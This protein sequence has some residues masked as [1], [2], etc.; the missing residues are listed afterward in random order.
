VEH[1]QT[2]L[3]WVSSWSYPQTSDEAGKIAGDKHSSLHG[4][5]V[6]DEKESFIR[7]RLGQ[8]KIIDGKYLPFI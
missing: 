3:F 7:L 6:S 2:I 4:L 1:I 8:V 5:F